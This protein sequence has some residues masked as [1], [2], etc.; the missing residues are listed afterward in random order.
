MSLAPAAHPSLPSAKPLA[1]RLLSPLAAEV[2]RFP[3]RYLLELPLAPAL[4][5]HVPG[6]DAA[7][8]ISIDGDA[9][10]GELALDPDEWRALVVGVEA[11]RV[12]P[13]DLAALLRRKASEPAYRVGALDALAGAQPDPR[14]TWDLAS[15]LDRLGAE[16]LSVEG[17]HAIPRAPA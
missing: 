5:L 12:W 4:A 14:E 7:V 17:S 6:L 9:D 1:G 3:A 16:L 8:R 10:E 15:V 11:D 2:L 13:R